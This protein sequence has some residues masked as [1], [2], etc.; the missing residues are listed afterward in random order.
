ML[1]DFTICLGV[2]TILL[3]QMLKKC[4]H[5]LAAQ[6]GVENYDV[7][8]VVVDNDLQPNSKAVVQEFAGS[9]PFPV[10]YFHEPRRGIPMARNKVLDAALALNAEWIVFVDDDQAA[11]HSFLQRH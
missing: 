6:Q 9:S 7:H 5:S 3:P 1:R 4:L 8:I 10:H 2:C 11:S